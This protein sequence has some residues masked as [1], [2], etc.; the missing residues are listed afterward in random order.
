MIRIPR[1]VGALVICGLCASCTLYRAATF[2]SDPRSFKQDSVETQLIVTTDDNGVCRPDKEAVAAIAAAVGVFLNIAESEIQ[3]YLDAK[4]K[5][6]TA[7]YTAQNN[8][9]PYYSGKP[10]YN[11]LGFDCMS[12]VRTI[13][14]GD[15]T[16]P[17][18][19]WLGS[20]K[21]N[22]SGTAWKIHTENV[23]LY[24]AAARTS[25]DSQKVDVSLE[26]KIKATTLD[27]KGSTSTTT[28][29]DET[30]KFPGLK[31]SAQGTSPTDVKTMNVESA[32]FP[33]IP[34]SQKE[35]DRCKVIEKCD[36]VSSVT[37]TVQVTET[38]SGGD[39]FGN[40]SKEVSDNAKS[41][42][43][44][45]NQALGGKAQSSGG[46]SKSK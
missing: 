14:N 4:K 12:L 22:S 45:V 30:L 44:A 26:I 18:F 8:L 40:L 16:T 15:S 9:D 37:V 1:V 43:D 34:R 3:S 35:I 6:F 29:A 23:N 36:G 42:N 33:A 20:L 21:P 19:A 27:D 46:T 10:D 17:A 31:I 32:W 7:T 28:V 39:S 5:E 24:W 11:T 38:G 41:F 25:K 13:K 2:K